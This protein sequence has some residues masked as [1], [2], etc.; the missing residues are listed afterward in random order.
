[1]CGR[2]TLMTDED[3]KDLEEIVREVSR[4][5][6]VQV[7]TDGDIYPTNDAPVLLGRDGRRLAD[8]FRWGFPNF[9]RKG[10]IINARAETAED[11]PTFRPCLDNGRCVIPASGFYEWGADKRKIRFYQPDHALYMAG[12]YRIYDGKPCYVILTT[13]ANPSVVDIHDRMPLVLQPDQIDPWLEDTGAALSIL[14][15][16]PPMLQRRYA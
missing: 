10:V 1:M 15:G 4:T 11:K 2:Y 3:Y 9:Y 14:H 5:T 16:T 7:K 8:L 12:L 13:A 6:E